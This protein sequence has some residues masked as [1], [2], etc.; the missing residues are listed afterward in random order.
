MMVYESTK[1]WVETLELT[2]ETRVLANLALGLAQRYDDKGETSTA[3]ELRKTC[4]ELRVMVG[5]VEKVD[6]LEALLK[7]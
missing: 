1:A 3:G 4:N 7:R 2:I 6:P 5:Q